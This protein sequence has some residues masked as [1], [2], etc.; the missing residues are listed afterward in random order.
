MKKILITAAVIVGSTVVFAQKNQVQ[1]AYSFSKAFD[2][3]GKCSELQ[4]GLEAINIA[5]QDET[6]KTWVKTWMY[7]GNLYYSV[8]LPTTDQNCKDLYK[9]A[10]DEATDSYLKALVLNFEDPELKKLDLNKEDGSD[11]IKFITA[12]CVG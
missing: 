3:N 2:R 7:R 1:T 8:L 5:I 10:L 6:T 12:F 9:E 4:N 11:M